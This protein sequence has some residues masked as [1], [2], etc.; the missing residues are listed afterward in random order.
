MEHLEFCEHCMDEYEYLVH[1]ILKKSI[2]KGEEIDYMG[3]EAFCSNC[4]NEIF[5][6][7]I[8]DYNLKILY[9]EYRKRHNIVMVEE[10]ESIINKYCIGKRPLSLL[11]GWGEQ[12]VSRYLDGDMPTK[13]YSDILKRVYE[14]PYYYL[15]ILEA[16]KEKIKVVAYN[17]SKEAVINLVGEINKDDKIDSVIK[18]LLIRCEDVTPLAL[19]KL[20]YYVQSFYYVFTGNFIF[21]E[22]CEAWV[23]GPVYRKVYDRYKKFGYEPIDTEVLGVNTI[24]LNDVEKSVIESVIK[25]YSCYSGKV[26]E[27]M[28]HNEK[29]WILTRAGF[30][31]T[32]SCN[33]IIEKDLIIQYFTEIK[34]RYN[35]I[36]L[37]DIQ[38]YSRDLFD[39]ISM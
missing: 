20:L 4:G 34:E 25:F 33:K 22:D 9:D 39:K 19:Q 37:L 3:K 16:G 10:I 18:Y 38:K 1:E 28:T 36:N 23:H 24:Q 7:E 35:M 29:P 32:D 11:L 2:L 21:K 26:L 17:K 6:S 30:S 12:T 15:D 8:S 13:Q 14:D 31:N 27:Q 5:V